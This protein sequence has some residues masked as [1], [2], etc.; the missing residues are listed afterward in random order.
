MEPVFAATVATGTL[1]APEI[2]GW[3]AARDSD[4]PNFIQKI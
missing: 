3:G 2:G 1:C 4:P